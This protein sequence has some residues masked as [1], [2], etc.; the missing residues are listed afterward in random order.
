MRYE[1]R[2]VRVTSIRDISTTV[3]AKKALQK[4]T[5]ELE[6][7][8]TIAYTLSTSLN[9]DDLLTTILE[10]AARVIKFDSAAIFLVEKDG[11]VSIDKAIGEAVFYENRKFTLK[12]TFLENIHLTPL[13][14]D[15][16]QSA[17]GFNNWENVSTKIRGWM[18]LPLIA[19]DLVLGYLTFDSNEPRAFSHQ[20]AALAESFS[21]H[22]A[23]A[24]YNA[25]LL[26]GIIQEVAKIEKEIQASNKLDLAVLNE[27]LKTLHQ[28]LKKALQAPSTSDSPHPP[29]AQDNRQR[30]T[31][32]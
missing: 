21:P 17:S 25:R 9:L 28:K 20:D 6:L 15:D 27:T 8:N 18:G 24:L 22:I 16:A 5:E 11:Q 13:I 14:L 29:Q 2:T 12:E 4:R 30:K 31:A 10:E 19:R 26:E 23:H 7:L 1:G 32:L 3:K